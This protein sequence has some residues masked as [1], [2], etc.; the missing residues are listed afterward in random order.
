MRCL[1]FLVT[2]IMLVDMSFAADTRTGTW[3]LN[4]EKSRVQNASAW[5]SRL[6]IF[7]AAGPGAYRVTFEDTRADGTVTRRTD[8]VSYDGK[9]NPTAG[10][11]VRVTT[12]IDDH[13]ATE[14]IEKDGK[15]VERLEEMISAD[16]RTMTN[17]LTGTYTNGRPMDE[18]RV[19]EKQ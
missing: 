14:V 15:E 19:W 7:E 17:H 3:K 4:L 2:M 9:K 13:H 12:L 8:L 6:M 5:K 11:R 16:G 1:R 10:D 18:I